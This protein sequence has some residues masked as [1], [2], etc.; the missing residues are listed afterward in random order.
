MAQEVPDGS[1]VISPKEFYDGVK[2]DI[3]AIKQAVSPLPE[4]RVRLEAHDGRLTKLE[5][6]AWVALGVASASGTTSLINFLG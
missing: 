2:D 3:A 4:L 5:R 6:L 1:I